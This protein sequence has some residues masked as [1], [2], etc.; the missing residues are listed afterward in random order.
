MGGA[1][2]RAP[3]AG[4]LC[5]ARS[6]P[7]PTRVRGRRGRRSGEVGAIAPRERGWGTQGGPLAAPGGRGA[8]G[9]PPVG[10]PS[11]RRGEAGDAPR[12]RGV[13][14][15]ERAPARGQ[16]L[17]GRGVRGA[18]GPEPGADSSREAAAPVQPLAERPRSGGRGRGLGPRPGVASRRPR[19]PSLGP[20]SAWPPG[21]H[22]SLPQ[23]MITFVAECFSFT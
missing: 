19:S 22:V 12:V 4:W 13:G 23:I 18:W 1:A 5:A 2:G 20:G 14:A 7:T 10:R 8:P 11:S 17:G 21:T 15:G 3:G 16:G 6:D 9:R